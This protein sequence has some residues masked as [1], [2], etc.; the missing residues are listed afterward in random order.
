MGILADFR[1][2]MAKADAFSRNLAR[3]YAQ[4]SNLLGKLVD[5]EPFSPHINPFDMEI[6]HAAVKDFILRLFAQPLPDNTTWGFKEV[7][8]FAD[9][10]EFFAAL[11]PAAR[12]IVL[13][14][15]PVEQ[16]SSYMRA[17]WRQKPD[18]GSEDG[19]EQ[20][21]QSVANAA[22]GWTRQYESLRQFASRHKDASMVVRFDELIDG[23]TL[24]K[25]VAH[26][27][28]APPDDE[29]TR[30]FSPGLPEAQTSQRCGQRKI[31]R[32]SMTSSLGR[33]FRLNT[34]TCCPSSLATGRL[35]AGQFR[36]RRPL[37]QREECAGDASPRRHVDE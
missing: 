35:R 17:P 14:R 25:L 19:I 2:A 23:S 27:G 5:S 36:L 32:C 6:L 11:F 9:D 20:L 30:T 29:G 28:I 12:F 16:M 21:R 10:L 13:V 24:V 34:T 4:R 37:Y 31:E 3:G 33:R 15:E 22:H 1:R 26:I 8:Y 7:R 18:L